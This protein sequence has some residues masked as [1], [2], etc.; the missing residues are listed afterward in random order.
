M[1]PIYPNGGVGATRAMQRRSDSRPL[2]G[3]GF[4]LAAIQMT[5]ETGI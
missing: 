2:R 5:I 3:T 1:I 4:R